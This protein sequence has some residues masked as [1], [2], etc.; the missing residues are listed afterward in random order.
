M[1]VFLSIGQVVQADH[2]AR[3]VLCRGTDIIALTASAK[4]CRAVRDLVSPKGIP[5]ICEENGISF[6]IVG[7]GTDIPKAVKMLRGVGELNDGRVC[8]RPQ[9]IF[10]DES[11]DDN[12]TVLF[13]KAVAGSQFTS[14]SL[15]EAVRVE[16][17]FG[18]WRRMGKLMGGK[19][20]SPDNLTWTSAF[21][22]TSEWHGA[23][24]EKVFGDGTVV[25]YC[26]NLQTIVPIVN[27]RQ[28]LAVSL[29]GN[30]Q[31]LADGL[32]K[33]SQVWT[34]QHYGR[35]T[36]PEQIHPWCIGPYVQRDK[37][38]IMQFTHLQGR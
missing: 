4:V 18:L 32:T 11:V 15:D 21:A 9:A 16:K 10:V 34:N 26:S 3:K 23:Y 38:G 24:A 17:V 14:P 19:R 35:F 6:A 30:A 36:D 2:D 12:F 5:V 22:E 25:M 7:L 33:P 1:R 20:T 8:F 31:Q 13:K 37:L 29:W 28:T 27:Q